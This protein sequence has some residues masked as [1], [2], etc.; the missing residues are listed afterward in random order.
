MLKWN[1]PG[2]LWNAPGLQWNG[3]P[4]PAPSPERRKNMAKVKL[5]SSTLSDAAMLEFARAH[6]L[7]MTGN[8]NF[9][10]PVPDAA[11]YLAGANALET[12]LTAMHNAEA[13]AHQAVLEKNAAR[14]AIDDFTRQRGNYVDG[15]ANGDA[16]KIASSG[17]AT[18][19]AAAPVGIPD[20]PHNFSASIGDMSGTMDVAWDRVRGASSYM[21]QKC[22]DPQNDAN[23]TFAGVSTKSSATISGLTPGTKYWFRVAAVGAAGQSAWSDPATKIAG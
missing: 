3:D 19:A 10:T 21:I 6:I 1:Q 12:T 7:D 17:F 13:A 2:I 11:A 14:Q 23:W 4:P 8:A 15:V 5:P 16:I 20:Q 9:T 18:K 22:P